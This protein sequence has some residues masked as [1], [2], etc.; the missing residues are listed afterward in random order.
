MS[1]NGGEDSPPPRVK[2]NAGVLP[3]LWES[4]SER[5]FLWR[6]KR[7]VNGGGIKEDFAGF[8]KAI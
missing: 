6:K 8:K 1:G 4:I 7:K 2:G 3:S 5:H